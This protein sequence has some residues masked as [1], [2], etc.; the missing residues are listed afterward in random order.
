[1]VSCGFLVLVGTAGLAL[2]VMDE[3]KRME[4]MFTKEDWDR[5]DDEGITDGDGSVMHMDVLT[6][7]FQNETDTFYFRFEPRHCDNMCREVAS[8]AS[9]PSINFSWRDA[10]AVNQQIRYAVTQH[11]FGTLEVG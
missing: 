9:D 11:Y 4:A 10:A 8:M 2:M 3:F 5:Q 6:I 7:R 1:M